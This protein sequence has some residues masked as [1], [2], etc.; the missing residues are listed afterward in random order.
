MSE[1]GEADEEQDSI[2]SKCITGKQGEH[3]QSLLV[4]TAVI[5]RS[6][7]ARW[8]GASSVIFLLQS[9]FNGPSQ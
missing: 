9:E 6:G 7:Q 4:I 3:M 5:K 2:I 1:R 8:K